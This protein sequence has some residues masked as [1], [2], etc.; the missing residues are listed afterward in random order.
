MTT[1]KA[2]FCLLFIIIF[3]LINY[4]VKLNVVSCQQ[5]ALKRE[6]EKLNPI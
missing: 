4:K 6:R 3:R 5:H 1:I 2:I